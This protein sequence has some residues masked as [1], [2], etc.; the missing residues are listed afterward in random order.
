MSGI[1]SLCKLLRILPDLSLWNTDNV[2]DMSL[3]FFGCSSL[4]SLPS[5]I[6][7]D[8]INRKDKMFE[9]CLSSI[10]NIIN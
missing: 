3:M 10:N 5:I 7:C 8:N 1:F 2:I 6:K 4:I 9:D